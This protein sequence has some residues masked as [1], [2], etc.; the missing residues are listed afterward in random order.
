MVFSP[1]SPIHLPRP[2]F[3]GGGDDGGGS[4]GGSGATSS[5]PGGYAGP[6]IDGSA[7]YG[8]GSDGSTTTSAGGHVSNAGRSVVSGGGGSVTSID[9]DGGRTTTSYGGGYT[10][11]IDRIDGGGPGRTGNSFGGT[12]GGISNATGASPKGSGI[13]ATGVAGAI[14]G[15]MDARSTTGGRIGGFIGSMLAGLPG[16][17]V[18]TMIGSGQ[19]NLGLNPGAEPGQLDAEIEGIMNDPNM[20]DG[21]KRQKIQQTITQAARETEAEMVANGYTGDMSVQQMADSVYGT[22][23]QASDGEE[24]TVVDGSQPPQ[25]ILDDPAAFLAGNSGTLS[26][27]TPTMDAN[28]AGATISDV[29]TPASDAINATTQ[30]AAPQDGIMTVPGQEAASYDAATV[31][32]R[33]QWRTAWRRLVKQLTSKDRYQT[34]LRSTHSRSIFRVRLP[35]PTQTV[36]PI[37]LVSHSA[38]PRRKTCHA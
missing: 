21:Q 30:T 12:F 34:S 24:T 13:E 31:A 16:A 22:T 23:Q 7:G 36:R 18:G 11:M 15:Y 28:A 5:A 26:D 10:G 4:G 29:N 8:I 32:A 38:T 9:R 3:G 1:F 33:R 19:L 14:D 2:V 17:V 25:S 27:I 20:G 35:A 37:L 6:N